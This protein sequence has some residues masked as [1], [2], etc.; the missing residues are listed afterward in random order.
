MLRT[1]TEPVPHEGIDNRLQP[2]DLGV[3]LALGGHYIGELAGLLKGERTQ[4]FKVFGKVRFHEHGRSESAGESPVNRQF[5]GLWACVR[6]APC[7]SP[8]PREAHPVAL[9]SAASHRP[10][11]PAT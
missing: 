5:A 10:E 1:R 6:H 11:Y 7:A 2:F 3:C 8:A 9:P 4:R